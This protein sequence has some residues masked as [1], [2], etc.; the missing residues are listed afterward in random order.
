MQA[1]KKS[2]QGNRLG[3]IMACP[4][5][6]EPTTFWFV[7]DSGFHHPF[8]SFQILSYA[9]KCYNVLS[10]NGYSWPYPTLFHPFFHPICKAVSASFIQLRPGKQYTPLYYTCKMCKTC[11]TV[12]SFLYICTPYIYN[13]FSVRIK[14]SVR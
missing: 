7:E 3:W 14:V 12:H 6:F 4:E 11:K 1:R 8:I 10:P 9:P 13:I 5:G 2:T